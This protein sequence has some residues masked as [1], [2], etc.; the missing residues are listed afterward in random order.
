MSR[1]GK[2]WK[3]LNA[4]QRF[5]VFASA[6]VQLVL[7]AL[8]LN[9]LKRRPAD[10]VRGSKRWWRAAVFLDTVGPIAYFVFARRRA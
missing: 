7:L 8:A 1:R 10:Q 4:G 3:D 2:S 6:A 5:G 9:D